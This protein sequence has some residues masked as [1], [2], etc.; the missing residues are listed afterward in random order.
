[1]R[2]SLVPNWS[3]EAKVKFATHNA[4]LESIDEKPTWKTVFSEQHCL[5]PLTD[6]I[7]PILPGI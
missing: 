4:R 7:E 1:M 2:Y 6:F 5:V 3:K